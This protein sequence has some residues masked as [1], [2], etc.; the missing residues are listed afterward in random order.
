MNTARFKKSI[1][2]FKEAQKYMPEGVN[3][4]V[5]AF[6]AVEAYPRYISKAEGSK[7]YDVDGNSYIDYICSWGPLI[8]GHADKDVVKALCR[9][10]QK[11]TSYGACSLLEIKMAK[12]VQKAMPSIELMRFVN[13]G[14]EATMSAVRLARGYTGK[15]KIIKFEGCYHGHY[16]SFLVKAGSGLMTFGTPTSAGIS[17]EIAKNTVVLPYNDLK[18]VK[19]KIKK[20]RKEIAAVIVEPVA[21]NMGV[22][23]P[24]KN[25]L[26][27]LREET[28]KYNI[29]LIFDEVITGFRVGPSGA[30]GYYKIKPDLTCLG[31]VIGGGL[32]VG[33]YGGKRSIMKQIS[34]CGPVY[35]A[36]T[37]SGNPLTLTAGIQTLKKIQ[38]Q[39][40]YEKLNEKTFYLISGMRDII[41]R[42][43]ISARVN[44]IASMFTLF[45]TSSEMKSAKDLALVDTKKY[46]GFF[47]RLL[48]EG[49]LLPPSA[50]EA[51]FVSSAHS[52]NDLKKTLKAVDKAI[53]EV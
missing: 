19:D 38:G 7:V 27:T 51:C 4:P 39:S 31:K 47:R 52:W 12:L 3:S 37:L 46:A 45:F 22:V 43:G 44:H 53:R 17:K 20:M 13:S 49:I 40:F 32:P 5:R 24:E 30:Q 36:G 28:E 2:F 25:F 15:E 33:L 18:A 23:L 6:K 42:N 14:T 34:P 48:A 8:L 26:E 29:L 41:K 11:G 50:Y 1:K 35:Q 9:Q 10:A 21:G 16:D